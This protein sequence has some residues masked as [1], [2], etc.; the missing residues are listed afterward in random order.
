[1]LKPETWP[2]FVENPHAKAE[3]LAVLQFWDLAISEKT[4]ADFT[5]GVTIGV[6][7]D[8]N[9]FLLEVRRGHWDFA[10]TLHEIGSMGKAWPNLTQVGIENVAYQAAAVQEAARRTMLPILP[11]TPDRDKVTRARLLEARANV[12][13]VYRPAVA[14]WWADFATEA[15]Y[16]PD[17]G[18]HDDQIDALSSAIKM[19]GWSAQSVGYAFGVHTCV[20]CAHMFMWESNRPCPKCGTKAPEKQENPDL[21]GGG[22][23][24]D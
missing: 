2:T 18:M 12:G 21:M 19:A 24:E 8:N 13:K 14:A 4:T 15:S 5:V 6:D 16:F 11:V 17:P 3:T 9:V 20:K 22:L 7:E 1:M 10:R 23:L